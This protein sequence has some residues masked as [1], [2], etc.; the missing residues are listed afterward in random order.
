MGAERI[1]RL[2]TGSPTP[3]G[4]GPGADLPIRAPEPR[5]HQPTLAP[6]E[7]WNRG[8]DH[9]PKSPFQVIFYGYFPLSSM[10]FGKALGCLLAGSI[11]TM[12]IEQGV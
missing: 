6:G 7:A 4:Q 12:L 2:A 9:N 8:Q 1:K 5:E 3:T 11:A 10:A